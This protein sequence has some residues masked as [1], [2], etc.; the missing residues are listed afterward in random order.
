MT[1]NNETTVRKIHDIT[2][3]KLT[4]YSWSLF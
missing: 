4:V 3:K 2:T 1:I